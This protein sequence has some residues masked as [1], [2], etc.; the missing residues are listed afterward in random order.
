MVL[1]NKSGEHV[2]RGGS[3]SLMVTVKLQ[4]LVLPAVSIAVQI[5]V[6]TP[7]GNAKPEVGTHVGRLTPG[8]LSVA[9]TVK[10]TT[11]VQRRKSVALTILV[12]QCMTGGS[13]SW[14][15]IEKLQTDLLPEA[16]S[17]VQFTGVVPLGKVE[18]FVAHG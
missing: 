13:Q 12:G 7:F 3:A 8:A 18:P 2:I 10:V 1:V 5:T 17:A 6:V 15:V 11:A 16:S 9:V 4:A 14:T